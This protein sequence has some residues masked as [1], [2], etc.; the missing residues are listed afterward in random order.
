MANTIDLI[1]N[2]PDSKPVRIFLPLKNASERF[3]VHGIYKKT[4]PPQFTL[5]FKP[6]ALPMEAIN[7]E[8]TCIVSIDMGGPNLSLEAKI[9]EVNNSQEFLM[10][11]EKSFSHEQMR[12]FF[13][14]DT[15]TSV[16][17]KAFQPSLRPGDGND[18]LIQGKTI[19]I[20][21]SGILASFPEPPPTDKL[22]R[23]ELTLPTEP[24]E[25]IKILAHHVRTIKVSEDQYDAAYHFED[26][27][28]EDRDRII[29]CCLQIQRKLL[30]L[31]VQV[32]NP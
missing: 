23:L 18:W 14:V 7:I 8:E 29:G 30:R 11:L 31:K 32:K 15:V 27:L 6:G 28:S 17:G 5:H 20:S 24:P 16:I 25:T 22:I 2:I 4:A 13:R 3:R 26:I 12:E 9:K 21:G 10:I 19:D 1:T